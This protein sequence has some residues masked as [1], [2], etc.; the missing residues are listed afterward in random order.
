MSSLVIRQHP[1][2]QWFDQ[3]PEDTSSIQTR[4][5][6]YAQQTMFRVTKVGMLQ[7]YTVQDQEKDQCTG[8]QA[9]LL[10]R[11]VIHPSLV[12]L[13][14]RHNL[15]L[16]CTRVSCVCMRNSSVGLGLSLNYGLF[17]E[18]SLLSPLPYQA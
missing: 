14:G 12:K 5:T 13:L 10:P 15:Q 16:E 18:L 3:E 17:V 11:N 2:L 8:V 6:H 1:L 7:V 4:G 9:S